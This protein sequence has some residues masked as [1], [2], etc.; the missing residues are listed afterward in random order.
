MTAQ[1]RVYVDCENNGAFV[2]LVTA[3]GPIKAYDKASS[4]ILKRSRL[5]MKTRE[6]KITKVRNG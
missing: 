1:W 5:P 4:L 6:V 3:T 2:E